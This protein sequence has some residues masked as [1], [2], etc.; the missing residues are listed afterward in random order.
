MSIAA[1]TLNGC[2]AEA[3][4]FLKL[5]Q[6]LFAKYQKKASYDS[7]KEVFSQNLQR[8]ITFCTK[9]KELVR[10]YRQK[11]FSDFEKLTGYAI[12]NF[13]YMESYFKKQN[14]GWDDTFRNFEVA[15]TR[16]KSI[17]ELIEIP[18]DATIQTTQASQEIAKQLASR[19]VFIV[20]GH[21][22]EN[23]LKLN[24]YLEGD[25]KL[26]AII[27]RYEPGKGRTLIEKFEQVAQQSGYAFVLWTSDDEVTTRD[28][29]TYGQPRPNV[30]FELGWFF[31][32]IGRNRVCILYKQGTK[33]PSDLGGISRIE[34][35]NSIEDKVGDIR[36]EL[37]DAGILKP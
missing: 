37:E 32:R 18:K 3:E 36:K 24:R 20:H 34:F 23:T 21:D 10:E 29:E 19:I 9:S 33:I 26:K 1:Q 13:H 15:I 27:L 6:T 16:M 7:I 31:G 5:K 30:I 8:I 14:Y 11:S 25:L 2:I 28:K 4:F 22:E 35:A 17:L 12:D